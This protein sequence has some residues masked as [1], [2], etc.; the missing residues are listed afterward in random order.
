MI[1]KTIRMWTFYSKTSAATNQKPDLEVYAP[2][3]P[4]RAIGVA[5]FLTVL[6]LAHAALAELPIPQQPAWTPVRDAV[7]LQE[8]EGRLETQEP[9]L[10]AAVLD[11]V[12]YV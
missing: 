6:A 8:I 3:K 7:Y 11:K 5:A 12:L 9:L 10:A 2:E 4:P 1:T